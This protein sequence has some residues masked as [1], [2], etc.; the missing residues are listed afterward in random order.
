MVGLSET[1]KEN[2]AKLLV[3]QL[4]DACKVKFPAYTLLIFGNCNIEVCADELTKL[5]PFNCH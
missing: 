3:P 2:K 5:M 4:F 1:C